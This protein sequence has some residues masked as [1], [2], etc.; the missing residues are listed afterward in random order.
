LLQRYLAVVV[1]VERVEESFR[2]LLCALQPEY[3][4]VAF[5]EFGGDVL[6]VA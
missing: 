2:K 5:E 3:A 6:P 1:Q 4:Q